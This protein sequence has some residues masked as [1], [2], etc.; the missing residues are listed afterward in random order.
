LLLGIAAPGAASTTAPVSL[1]ASA[2]VSR[3]QDLRYAV[4]VYNAKL[5]D[6][7]PQV[8]SQLTISQ[9]GRV[10]FKEPE[11]VL[12]VPDRNPSQVVKVGQLGTSHVPRGRY[13]MTL[14]ITDAFADK[15]AN[16]VSRSMDFEVID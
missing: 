13:T 16:T 2:Q 5:K 10:V 9:N 14:V 11:E 6:G 12:P 7:K 3:K 8:R 1:A 15:K 4:F